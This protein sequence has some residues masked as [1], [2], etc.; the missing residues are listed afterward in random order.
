MTHEYSF[1]PPLKCCHREKKKYFSLHRFRMGKMSTLYLVEGGSFSFDDD[2]NNHDGF[3][4]IVQIFS[5]YCDKNTATENQ[6]NQTIEFFAIRKILQITKKLFFS[7]YSPF[8][9]IFPIL[10]MPKCGSIFENSVINIVQ[11]E[12][13]Y[14]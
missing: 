3:S 2:H 13:Q 8:Y 1:L 10:S 12:K 11:N 7:L 9:I 14:L 6:T 5:S 4:Y